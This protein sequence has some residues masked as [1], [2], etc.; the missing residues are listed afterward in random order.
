MG[1]ENL[2]VPKQLSQVTLWVHPEGIV[3]GA[4]FLSI[5]HDPASPEDPLQVLNHTSP[6]IVVRREDPDDL[7]FYNK[8]S[9]VRVHYRAEE[10]ESFDLPRLQCTLHMMD[11]SLLRGAIRRDLPPD[12]SRFYDFLNLEEE[13]FAKLY[14]EEDQVC[15]VNKSYI[16]CGLDESAH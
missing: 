6:F 7:R 15:L 14:L 11:G 9:I 8:S 2:I 1:S 3:E 12:R 13:R 4:L 16:V 5:E 10:A